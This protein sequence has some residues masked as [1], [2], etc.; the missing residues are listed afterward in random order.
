MK[1]VLFVVIFLLIGAFF[2]VSNGNLHL[3]NPEQREEFFKNY[4][5]WFM[6]IFDNSKSVTGYVVN[7]NWLP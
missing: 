5:T 1:I 7:M 4:Y 3:G 2:I 6:K